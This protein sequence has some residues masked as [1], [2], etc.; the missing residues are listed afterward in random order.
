MTSTIGIPIKLLNEAQNH[1]VTLEITSGQVYR[2]KLIEAEDNMN[3]QLKDIT[4]TARDGRVSHL[5]QVYIRGSH[6]RFFIVPDMLRNAP[7]FRSRGVRGRGVGMARGRA[8][9]NRA[10]G[11]RGSELPL[12][13]PYYIATVPIW[14][15]SISPSHDILQEWS[16]EWLSSEAAEVV[17]N[18]GAWVV[19]VRKP[20]GQQANNE[21]GVV[22]LDKIRQ[23]LTTI[24]KVHTR[25]RDTSNK[26]NALDSEPILL[27]LGMSQPLRPLLEISN[28]EWEDLCQDCG[29]WEWIDGEATGKNGFG[30]N[31]GLERLK[32]ALE[33]NE[34]D[35]GIEDT[36]DK[37]DLENEL[38]LGDIRFRDEQLELETDSTGM[39]EAILTH[40]QDGGQGDSEGDMQVQKLES[41][42]LKMQALKE[43]GAA[44]PDEERRKLA[45]KA[46]R[47]IMKSM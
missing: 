13:T 1:V 11:Q 25:H 23:T 36:D 41:M 40:D 43:K 29:G 8:T 34:W 35:S 47:E 42:M 7:M 15:D 10:R 6:V 12:A 38:G 9:V 28:D 19:V 46:V 22:S 27:V 21:E 2:G 26:Y 5:D 30:E 37:D 32:E 18:I 24:H 14:H 31:V 4:V 33:A 3:V 20:P 16:T 45:A 17:Q 44:L 39:H